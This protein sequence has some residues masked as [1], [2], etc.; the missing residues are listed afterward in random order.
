MFEL[1]CG[2]QEEEEGE[3]DTDQGWPGRA[4]VPIVHGKLRYCLLLLMVELWRGVV[5]QH[6]QRLWVTDAPLRPFKFSLSR[7]FF[8]VASGTS[9]T[10]SHSQCIGSFVSTLCQD[11]W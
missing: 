8:W 7:S 10:C 4:S 1:A 2:A 11:Q 6:S 9:P 3:G 5:A